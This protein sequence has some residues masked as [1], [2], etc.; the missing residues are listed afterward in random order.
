H[1]FFK[2]CLFLG[3]ASVIHGNGDNQD[4]RIMGGFKRYLPITAGAFV[5]AWLA[6]AGVPP[7]SGFWAKDEVLA[8]AFFADGYA[9]WVVGLLAAVLTGAYMTRQVLLVFFGNERWRAVPDGDAEHGHAEHGH[10]EHGAGEGHEVSVRTTTP[11]V[12]YGDPAPRPFLTH[13]PHE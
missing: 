3:S 9:L 11:T 13:A 4:M 1:A 5:V 12:A 10:A 8:R 6:I 7:F 2:A